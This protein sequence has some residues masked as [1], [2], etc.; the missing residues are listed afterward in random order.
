MT[1]PPT[2]DGWSY[3]SD[4]EVAMWFWIGALLVV[5]FLVGA[6]GYS[7]TEAQ[8]LDRELKEREQAAMSDRESLR[9][10]LKDIETRAR[11]MLPAVESIVRS[12]A[13]AGR[14]ATWAHDAVDKLRGM[15]GELDALEPKGKPR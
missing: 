4:K 8:M 11:T 1:K 3:A 15:L 5:L 9:R 7:W 14:D 13:Q 10:Q 2:P 6:V 12:E